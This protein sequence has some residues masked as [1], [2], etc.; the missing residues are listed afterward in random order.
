MRKAAV[1]AEVV[2][3]FV[4]PWL[5]YRIALPSM[6]ETEALI[7]SAAPPVIWSLLL[8]LCVRRLDVVSLVIIAGILLSLL[9]MTLGGSPRLLL[10]RESLITGM[11][12]ISLLVSMLLPR[13][14][15]YYL[16]QATTARHSPQEAAQFNLL[17]ERPAFV[18]T[19][20]VISWVW[21][22]VLVSEAL[23][24]AFL[25]WSIPVDQF[26]LISPTI[27]YT[28]YGVLIVWTFWFVRRV[29][30]AARKAALNV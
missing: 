13:P 7:L 1:A 27:A 5:C 15:M 12:G 9:A 25:A 19:I 22:T 26:L 29:K 24:R 10:L 16:A 28:V 20:Y 11:V 18:R 30:A 21:G 4:L 23:L 8:V 14:L 6:G 3:N 17:W 2:V